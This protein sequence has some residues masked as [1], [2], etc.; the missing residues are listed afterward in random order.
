V[1]DQRF[2]FEGEKKL[3]MA[4]PERYEDHLLNERATVIH[5]PLEIDQPICCGCRHLVRIGAGSAWCH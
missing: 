3:V 2:A 1:C 5:P 4:Q